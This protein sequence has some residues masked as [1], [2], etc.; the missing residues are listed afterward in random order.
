[1]WTSASRGLSERLK[2]A[3]VCLAG[4]ASIAATGPSLAGMWGAGDALLAIDA[5]GGR[6]QVG[7]QLVRFASPRLDAQGRFSTAA[8]VERLSLRL[9][10]EDEAEEAA[11]P[12]TLSGRIA[13]GAAELVL[14]VDGQPPRNVR[15]MLGQRGKPARC[16]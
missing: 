9:P 14:T 4:A 10:E 5:Q 16:L 7:C 8:Q 12:A 1:M 6:L 2:L 13:D 3:L 15:L 11:R